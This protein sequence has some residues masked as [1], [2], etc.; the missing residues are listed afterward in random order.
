MLKFLEEN[1]Y[2]CESL[3]L[4]ADWEEVGYFWESYN[5]PISGVKYS[6]FKT[7]VHDKACWCGEGCPDTEM[8]RTKK[9]EDEDRALQAR[10]ARYQ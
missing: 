2:T 9:R 8:V 6:D 10:F 7:L 3:K 5:G 1:G 4:K